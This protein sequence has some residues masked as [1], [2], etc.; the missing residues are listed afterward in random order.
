VVPEICGSSRGRVKVPR[1]SSHEQKSSADREKY[2]ATT[3]RQKPTP[4]VDETTP[5]FDS[6]ETPLPPITEKTAPPQ[7]TRRPKRRFSWLRENWLKA[8]GWGVG[9]VIVPVGG[10]ALYQLYSLNR[11]VG[12]I[13]VQIDGGT[14]QEQQLRE[15]LR[16]FEDQM[17]QE[18]DRMNDRFDRSLRSR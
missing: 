13:R 9:A 14:K 15:D 4:T 5:D 16:R 17:R 18:M 12:E 3:V 6:T 1:R 2:W 7:P 11:E 10:W 8:L